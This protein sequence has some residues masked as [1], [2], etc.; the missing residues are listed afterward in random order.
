M[1]EYKKKEALSPHFLLFGLDDATKYTIR[2]TNNISIIDYSSF[3]VFP[4][5][6]LKISIRP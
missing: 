6:L 4:T 1:C 5:N 2:I 3:S